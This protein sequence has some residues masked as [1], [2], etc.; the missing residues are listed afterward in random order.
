M[1]D[2]QPGLHQVHVLYVV[3]SD[4][5][6][7]KIESQIERSIQ[8]GNDWFSEQTGGSQIRFDTYQGRLDITLVQINAEEEYMY[9][10]GYY[11]LNRLWAEV[12]NLGFPISE[13]KYYLL[14]YDGRNID[15]CADSIAPGQIGANYLQATY[16]YDG[17]DY[18]CVPSLTDP[19]VYLGS[20]HEILHGLGYV[21]GCSPHWVDKHLIDN[22]R[23][24]M[25]TGE[26]DWDIYNMVLD[27]GHDDYYNHD[28]PNCPD[29]ANSAF[30]DP[31]PENAE[32]PP[33]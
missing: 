11:A 1:P 2:D 28:I 9:S 18:P 3:P 23:D 16:S 33:W 8:L 29:L 21:F 6:P 15:R 10:R 20:I 14:F 25:Y 22:P 17:T 32:A 4:K 12:G 26:Y 19:Y 13:T 7:R 5:T 30:L 24:L 31:L 27:V